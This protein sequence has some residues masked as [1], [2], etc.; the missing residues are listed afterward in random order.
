LSFVLDSSVTLSWYFE[1]QST[2][3]TLALLDRVTE[4]GAIVPPLWRLEVFNGFQSALRRK[5]IDRSYRDA[6]LIDLS[7]LPITV[8]TETDFHLKDRTLGLADRFDLTIYDA[9]FLELAERRELPL[10]SLDQKL[11][12]AAD[13]IGIEL[14]G[15]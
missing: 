9:V 15:L 4:K 5:K 7:L 14:L 3:A 11:R 1:D 12:S 13:G 8:D 10:A 2:P 6:S